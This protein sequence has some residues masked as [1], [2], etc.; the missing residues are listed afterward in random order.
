MPAPAQRTRWLA[1]LLVNVEIRGDGQ[2]DIPD[3]EYSSS[4]GKTENKARHPR[5]A[6]DRW[7]STKFVADAPVT[8][9]SFRF[10]RC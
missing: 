1:G 8:S 6:D 9:L 4:R 10:S 2:G 3:A 7:K 5:L